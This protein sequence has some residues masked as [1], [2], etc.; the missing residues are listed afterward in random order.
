M[1]DLGYI[2]KHF[3]KIDPIVAVFLIRVA[4]DPID[5][6]KLCRGSFPQLQFG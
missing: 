6:T 4:F 2:Q 3:K 1:E 5:S